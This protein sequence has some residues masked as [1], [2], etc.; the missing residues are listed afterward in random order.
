VQ[1]KRMRFYEQ[2]DLRPKNR[3]REGI[4]PG[5]KIMPNLPKDESLQSC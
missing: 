1:H 4:N 5:V 2:W 3:K